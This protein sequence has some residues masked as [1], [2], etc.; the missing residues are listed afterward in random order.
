MSYDN[1]VEDTLRERIE[2]LK[3]ALRALL[4]AYINSEE[5]LGWEYGQEFKP[6]EDELVIATRKALEE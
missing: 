6:D 4:E 2:E 1:E 3:T 5:A